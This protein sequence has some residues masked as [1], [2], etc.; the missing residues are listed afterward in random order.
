MCS[1]EMKNE[2]YAEWKKLKNA[3]QIKYERMIIYLSPTYT[4]ELLTECID[5]KNKAENDFVFR[6]FK[7]PNVSTIINEC[8]Q[9]IYHNKVK[10]GVR[11]PRPVGSGTSKLTGAS[12]D[13][14]IT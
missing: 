1:G 5:F 6:V 3:D 11:R 7:D 13:Y 12:E 9:N 8:F 4:D 2:I 10:D 14:F